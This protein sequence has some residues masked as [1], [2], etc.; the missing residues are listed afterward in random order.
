VVSELK[1]QPIVVL[2]E[3]EHRALEG[4]L[5]QRIR[6]WSVLWS[7]APQPLYV[8]LVAPETD[9]ELDLPAGPLIV[10]EVRGE[11]GELSVAL[12]AQLLPSL[13]GLKS[14]EASGVA[15]TH[16]DPGS[17]ASTLLTR[18]MES[19][20]QA[21]MKQQG[22]QIRVRR[23]EDCVGT[24]WRKCSDSGQWTL[25]VRD[26]SE[27]TLLI[28]RCS[29]AV[30]ESLR[31]RG[32]S[33]PRLKGL[34]RRSE[35]LDSELVSLKAVLGSLEIPVAELMQLALGDVLMFSENVDEQVVLEGGRGEH[36]AVGRLGQ[37]MAR[38]RALLIS[39]VASPARSARVA[40]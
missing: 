17:A 33:Q 23:R 15:S 28:A 34:A 2:G 19:L 10:I 39:N 11:V 31:T 29:A 37:S 16:V 13:L 12:P 38:Q 5:V 8:S 21:V 25:V 20:G 18:L 35:M 4:T 1:W 30:V 9:I 3:N 24:Q 27:R 22:G 40:S 6:D 26:E 14:C 32:S 36:V 7:A